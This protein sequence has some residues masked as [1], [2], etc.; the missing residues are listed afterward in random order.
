MRTK[1]NR[2]NWSR[3]V[4]CFGLPLL[5]VALLAFAVGSPVAKADGN[6]E[7]GVVPPDT[8]IDGKTYEEW[9]A[10]WWQWVLE[11]PVYSNPL[12]D[13]TGK[14]AHKNQSG[15]VWFLAGV[16][17]ATEVTRYAAVPAD[18]YIFFPLVNNVWAQWPGDPELSPEDIDFIRDVYL[19]P[20]VDGAT[21]MMCTIDDT[22]EISAQAVRTESDLFGVTYPKKN[23]FAPDCVKGY[24]FPCFDEGVYLM[25]EP[26]QPGLHK[27][28]F[29]VEGYVEAWDYPYQFTVTYYLKV[30]DEDEQ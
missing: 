28:H 30:E 13:T 18:K 21:N 4:L 23:L 19:S 24:G 16:T 6:S 7:P 27:I 20:Y 15:P 14:F 10:C 17:G 22:Y 25:L 29:S 1:K 26:L 12:L 11:V 2:R 9:S 3:V 5:T 8:L